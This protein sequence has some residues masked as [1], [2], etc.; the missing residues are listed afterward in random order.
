[1]PFLTVFPVA[2]GTLR[3]QNLDGM[4]YGFR[5]ARRRNGL[6]SWPLSS[7]AKRAS[8]NMR[9]TTYSSMRLPSGVCAPVW[10]AGGWETANI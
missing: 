6:D 5:E 10:C 9:F 3:N 2:N 4:R 1:M 8:G 7:C